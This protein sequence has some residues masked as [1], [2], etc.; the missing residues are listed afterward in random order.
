MSNF[1]SN[2]KISVWDD[3]LINGEFVEQKICDIGSDEMMYQ[4][5]VLEP[6]LVKKANGEKKLTFS[7]YKQFTDHVTGQ[8]VNNPFSDYLI[9][10]RKV[11]LY[12]E[13]TWYDF[14]VKNIEENSTTYLYKYSL[15]DAL[16]Q[17]LSKN[18][19]DQAFDVGLM[20]NLGS[21][22]ELGSRA[23]EPTNWDV[24]SDLFT[25]LVEENLV[26]V[27]TTTPIKAYRIYTEGEDI[28]FE[29]PST[30][31]EGSVLLAFYSCCKNKPHRF[32][33]IYLN[34][35]YGEY[36]KDLVKVDENR[37]IIVPN[38]QYYV[39]VSSTNEYH[40][41]AD[42]FLP[43]SM[44]TVVRGSN[45]LGNVV[46][47]TISNWY[48]G[49][50]FGYAQR[51]QYVPLLNKYC[52]IFNKQNGDM[53]ETDA[54]GEPI[55]YFG[56]SNTEFLSPFYVSNIITNPTFEGITGW[57]GCYLGTTPNAKV[58]YGA[59]ITPEFGHFVEGQFESA[60]QILRNGTF[61]PKNYKPFLHVDCPAAG[62][63]DSDNHCFVMNSGFYDHRIEINNVTAGENWRFEFVVRIDGAVVAIN[64]IT[65]YFDI[66]LYEVK[67]NPRTGG[68]QL[69][70]R[71][72]SFLVEDGKG[73]MKFSTSISP[74]L[75]PAEFQKK[76]IRLIIKPKKMAAAEFYIEE[77]KMYKNVQDDNGQ[78]IVPDEY[79]TSGVIVEEFHF[80]TEGALLLAQSLD[81]LP[82]TKIKASELNY[83][84]YIPVYNDGAEKIR[85]ITIKE[86][87][88]FNI[89][90]S[91]SETFEA[92]LELKI[93]R[94]DK[95]N[96]GRITRKIAKFKKYL[97]DDNY[98]AFRYGIN[99]KD[100]KR[101][102][103]S[104][105]LTTK[106]IVK[107]NRNELAPDGF[108]TIAYAGSNPTGEDSIYDFRYF[109]NNGMLPAV[110]YVS[111]LYYAQNPYTFEEQFGPD[112][113]EKA[114]ESNVQNYFNRI[115]SINDKAKVLADEL[116]ELS[117]EQVDL[118]AEVEV[119][120][121]LIKTSEEGIEEV[122]E[123]FFILTGFYPEEVNTNPFD[124]IDI[125]EAGSQPI[126]T[127]WKNLN[128]VSVNST[129]KGTQSSTSWNFKVDLCKDYDSPLTVPDKVSN[130]STASP[131]N[132]IVRY[133]LASL[134]SVSNG[135][136]I[137]TGTKAE[138][139]AAISPTVGYVVGGH[140]ELSY[141]LTVNSGSLTSIGTLSNNFTNVKI[142]IDGGATFTAGA[143]RE[144]TAKTSGSIKVI[145]RGT[146]YSGSATDI[147]KN[148][149]I[150]P[151]KGKTT[152][153]TCTIT[154]LTL[155]T[156][157]VVSSTRAATYAFNKKFILSRGDSD[158]REI[159]EKITC[160][161]PGYQLTGETNYSLSLIDTSG[162]SL[163]NKL[164]EY[165]RLQQQ[166]VDAERV[167]GNES[168]GLRKALNDVDTRIAAINSSLEQLR[169]WKA[170]LNKAF[171]TIYSRF[172]T[173]G[174][175][176][177][178]EYVDHDKYYNDALSVL[179]NSCLP[180]VAYSVN[181]VAV[182]SLPGYEFFKFNLGDKTYVIDPDFFGTEGKIEVVITE[183]II[184]LDDPSKN[185]IKVQTFKNQFQDLFQKITATVQQVQ[186]STGSY[187]KAAALAEADVQ[188]RGKFVTDALAGMSGKLAVAGQTSVVM[189]ESGI[190]LTDSSTKDQMR[191]IG[192]AIL[193]G[194]EDPESGE[195]SWKTGLTPEGI[196]ASLI[197]AG[198]LNAGNIIIMNGN[199]PVF[200]WDAFGIS[201]FDVDWA[202]GVVS[203]MANPYKFVRF[204]KHGIYG[205]NQ[206]DSGA[207][208][209]GRTWTPATIDDIDEL[210][211]F[212]LTWE[213][214]K[215]T[216][217]EGVVARIG[218]Q[219]YSILENGVAVPRNAIM[220]VT[221]D[222]DN[223]F[224][225]TN[226]G[227]V[228]VSGTV[229]AKDG[230][231]GPFSLSQ[232]GFICRALPISEDGPYA[233][234]KEENM[235][236]IIKLTKEGLV[237][238]TKV[239]D[240]V[241]SYITPS[242]VFT[243]KY[244]TNEPEE[245]F[246][247]E[248]THMIE[249]GQATA[250]ISG[251]RIVVQGDIEM[252]GTIELRHGNIR[253]NN[254][255]RIY[256]GGS[257]R[258]ITIKG[259]L[260]PEHNTTGKL[261]TSDY[262]WDYVYSNTAQIKVL[263]VRKTFWIENLSLDEDDFIGMLQLCERGQIQNLQVPELSKDDI[264]LNKDRLKTILKHAGIIK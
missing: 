202:N 134:S 59:Q 185:N 207:A 31:P 262:P 38:C 107:Q 206:E 116:S 65:E 60:E 100:I 173:E 110:D 251:T 226:E 158:S 111:Q 63:N 53:L 135:F 150:Q 243:S 146:Y 151:N 87:N 247:I 141:T 119:Q 81:D 23:L 36:N 16:V 169:T 13:D 197:T 6:Q 85:T 129:Q 104:K 187:E 188:V 253:D 259:N 216:G 155:K 245:F 89:L 137:T 108:C 152:R 189:D 90:Q 33:F 76:N 96:P 140:Y 181:V 205:I 211:S 153:V 222:K 77:I 162:S 176:I 142:S 46:D 54:S 219:T 26:Y 50:R 168:S 99:L 209:D 4:G 121:A 66:S 236:D 246:R 118:K 44:D 174:T 184:H 212:A 229:H 17:E 84:Q 126:N 57:T 78:D 127:A 7:M 214:L 249:T 199:E 10:E 9:S 191:L 172:I 241:H 93:E 94:T 136:K 256:L 177:S 194:V 203:G 244:L 112:I 239:S 183:Q 166:L 170:E 123:D 27:I 82:I 117:I 69:L 1:I 55:K 73:W 171:Y 161:I 220:R 45:P 223:T 43:F 217:D 255:K 41:S 42:F 240:K 20:N 201:A 39:D 35:E 79:D 190:T 5:K 231:I 237:F 83:E 167:L 120:E 180:Q 18:G 160:E 221:K 98:A 30:I 68:H 101:T 75:T 143:K 165:V 37:I 154:G 56:Y 71:W 235:M 114:G 213:G 182:S 67:Y 264:Y 224:L 133:E 122:R 51:V 74:S 138:A 210:S 195:R 258:D 198:T 92:W 34:E 95:E 164:T 125:E 248:G 11:K 21:A 257:D 233:D 193:M 19:F 102:Y 130:I 230:I 260:T 62:I 227:D 97:G 24:E 49:K 61:D 157:S 103:E 124:S 70:S 132:N 47:T 225:I 261:G 242:I 263:N 156:K 8:K 128:N 204:D 32:Q 15:E 238:N 149:F 58:E 147:K 139:G 2:Y 25:E 218:R 159:I 250:T 105:K 14:I 163:S 48:R 252:A 192:G 91:I 196:S 254:E 115:K 208:Y 80:V 179:Y 234:D 232:E 3:V 113:D 64:S 88:Y 52:K 175:W 144:F 178:E 29:T 228:I 200:R 215:V 86:S 186:Y 40:E 131:L 148:L 22:Q 145:V 28:S 106:L 12:Y 109:H 72:A